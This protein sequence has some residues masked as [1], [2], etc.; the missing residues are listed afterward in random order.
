MLL[1][2]IWPI[3]ALICLGFVLSRR[4]FP[5]GPF[6]PAAERLNYFVLFPALLVSS[7]A[8]APVRDP[9]L[10][11]FGGAAAVTIFVAAV[12]LTVARR[13]RPVTPAR[14]GPMLQGVVRFNTYLSLALI[15]I[16]TGDA[17]V[18]RAAV[19]LAI[20]VPLVNVLSIL[21]LSGGGASRSPMRLGRTVLA[22]PLILA[23]LAGFALALGGIGLPLGS[24]DL[25]RLLGQASLPLGLLCVGAALNPAAL[26]QDM[27]PL[28][29]VGGARLLAMPA[30]AA[31]TGH[32][33]GLAGIEIA[34]LVIFSAVPTAPTSY[35]LT[36]QMGG[37][38]ALM[39]GIVTS[40]TLAA[41]ATIPLVLLLLAGL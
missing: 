21:A 32:T 26:R 34:V 40:Q 15:A 29:L 25:L 30:L 23:C 14:F 18:E 9:D 2:T 13:V 33:F 8:N 1:I 3:F 22:N 39:A 16:L 6:W 27:A 31:A 17:G 19:Y 24:G 12:L 7:L 41:L 11:R 10:L 4:D 20:C 35:V 36:R 5:S 38:G 28:S 37:D